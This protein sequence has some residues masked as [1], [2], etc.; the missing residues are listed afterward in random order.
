MSRQ[1]ELPHGSG[2]GRALYFEADD[3]GHWAVAWAEPA[4]AFQYGHNVR[5]DF[6][7]RDKAMSV[8]VLPR[9]LRADHMRM[10]VW[11]VTVRPKE[12]R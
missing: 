8:K 12:A 7:N 5:A 9:T 3:D 2:V 4:D 10:T 11:V 1:V 6:H